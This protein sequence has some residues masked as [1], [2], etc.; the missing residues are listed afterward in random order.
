VLNPDGPGTAPRPFTFAV[1][2][3][4]WPILTILTDYVLKN[5]AG[6]KIG[7][8]HDPTAYGQNQ[9]D[10]TLRLLSEQGIT[11]VA[12]EALPV[13]TADPSNQVNKVLDAGAEVVY[14]LVSF[15]D[16]ARVAKAI[17]ARGSDAQII[18]T[19]QCAVIPDFIKNAGDAAEGVVTTRVEGTALPPTAELTAFSERYNALTGYTSFPPPDWAAATYD[20]AKI[21]FDIWSRVGTQPSKVFSEFEKVAGYKGLACSNISFSPT[22]HNG[23]GETDCYRLMQ[24]KDGQPVVMEGQ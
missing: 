7:I 3:G 10:F 11:P 15:D 22:Q 12:V 19:D 5:H 2:T 20:T 18:C 21:L 16:V 9:R 17:R 1:L 8:I 23:L 4:N 14:A 24:I 13:N 6:E